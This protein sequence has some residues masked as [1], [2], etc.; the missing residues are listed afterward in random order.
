VNE[1]ASSTPDASDAAPRE[2][3]PYARSRESFREPPVGFLAT[4]RHLGP[5]MILVGSIVG[6]GELIMT[7][8]LGAQAGFVLL[9]FVLISC[10]IK[11][12]VQA[13]IARHTISSGKTILAV[14]NSLPGPAGRRPVW[15]NLEWMAVL[16]IGSLLGVT[17][18]IQLGKAPSVALFG[19][20]SLAALAVG[21]A[22]FIK[23]RAA[24]RRT[25][26]EVGTE[27][28]LEPRPRVNW[29]IWAWMPTQLLLFIN[30]GAIVGGAGQTLQLAFPGV[31]GEGGDRVWA[32]VVAA[33]CAAILLGGG[34]RL[35]ERVSIGLVAAFTCVTV[36]CAFL[37]QWT[38]FAITPAELHAGLAFHLPANVGLV[39]G[40]AL[41]M[42]AGTGIGT[43]EMMAYTYWCVEKGY[44]RNTGAR[45]PGDDW[46]RRARGW[47]R[48]MYTDVVLT[49]IVY[50]ISTV[51]FY[52]LGA[53][54]LYPHY[55]PKGT[56]T[57]AILQ[58]VYTSSLG[59]WAATLFVV[60]AFFVLFSTVVSG[61]A[62]GSRILADALCVTGLVDP[63][64]YSARRRFI[65][66]FVVLSLGIHVFTYSLFQD[67]TLMLVI[68]SLIA[69]VLYPI[70]GL[71]A[72]YLR[73]R[74]VDAR[75]RPGRGISALLWT[76]GIAIA[77]ISP[78]VAVLQVAFGLKW[79][80]G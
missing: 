56:Q 27:T 64:E 62:G 30:G 39:L 2:V 18:Y 19:L 11:V 48:V 46:P 61:V 25:F 78:A 50:T 23:W 7:T 13:E 12:V 8:K 58:M 21:W 22:L 31:F 10:V 17:A 26:L 6:S 70:F 36:V 79:L 45:Q 59:T 38:D 54:I 67:P 5:G 69:V 53:A 44:A 71:G 28:D 32:V 15:L 72:I 16:V 47:I 68:S 60:G 9:W 52:F 49:M 20:L 76:C 1:S 63:G 24:R 14:F 40:T 34:Y 42:Y 66:I 43:G 41:A 51:C 77:L 4:L 75:I 35:L 57:L 74:D 3:N 73:Y 80:G 33:A 37:L 55:D 29:F 65:H